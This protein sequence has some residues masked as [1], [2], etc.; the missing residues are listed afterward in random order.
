VSGHLDRAIAHRRMWAER[1]TRTAYEGDTQLEL[2]FVDSQLAIAAA[3]VEQAEA[4]QRLVAAVEALARTAGRT[5]QHEDW[6]PTTAAHASSV[7]MAAFTLDG[8][9]RHDDRP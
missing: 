1:V 8:L 5:D 9:T 7:T 4:V 6:D 2:A 3:A